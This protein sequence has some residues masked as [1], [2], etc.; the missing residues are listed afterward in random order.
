[1]TANRTDINRN[2][3][4]NMNSMKYTETGRISVRISICGLESGIIVI[5][6]RM[7]RAEVLLSFSVLIRDLSVAVKLYHGKSANLH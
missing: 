7:L 3:P 1:M 5:V 2:I 4:M 6:I